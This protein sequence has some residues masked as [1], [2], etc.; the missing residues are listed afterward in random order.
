MNGVLAT[1]LD[2]T[3]IPLSGD[4]QNQADLKVLASHLQGCSTT[5]VFV[6]GRHFELAIRAI[7]EFSLPL[8]DWIIS[9]VGTAVHQRAPNDDYTEVQAYADHLSARV[10]TSDRSQLEQVLVGFSDVSLQ[11]PEKQSPFKMSFYVAGHQLEHVVNRLAEQPQTERHAIVSS[12]DPQ[13][14]VG[15]L[16]ILPSGVSKSYA[17]QWWAS[18]FE[19]AQQRIIFAGDSGNDVA[20]LT[21]GF[22]AIVVGNAHPDVKSAVKAAHAASDWSDRLFLAEQPATSGVLAGCRH[23]GLFDER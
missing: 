9:N 3:L 6:T 10:S 23:F 7:D 14:G 17:L 22:K 1:D 5:L 21:C 15:L 4:T 8:P 16:D 18:Q 2:H 20:A 12:V 11:E 13:T 19:V